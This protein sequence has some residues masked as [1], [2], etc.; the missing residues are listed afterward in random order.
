MKCNTCQIE[1][2]RLKKE[3]RKYKRLS[4]HD[5]LTELYNR[6]KLEH[7]IDRYLHLRERYKIDFLVVMIDIDRFKNINDS[8]G[9]Q[10]GDMILKRVANTL[11]NNIRK[12]DKAY[13]LGGDEFVLILSHYKEDKKILNRIRDELKKYNV[14][15]S[16]GCCKMCDDVLDIA[17]KRMYIE[18]RKKNDNN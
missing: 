6:R 14:E 18:K 11:K 10:Y 17:D 2:D 16:I 3:L 12:F 4:I 15:I 5:I 8:Q 7:D 13:R 9:H 1:M